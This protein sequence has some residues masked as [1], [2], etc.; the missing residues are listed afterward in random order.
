LDE[1]QP[2][3]ADP[4][5][6]TP[7]FSVVIPVYNRLDYTRE[8]LQAFLHPHA[9][10]IEVIVV[11]DGSTDETAEVVQSLARESC[12]AQIRLIRQSNSGPS[13]ARNHGLSE[14]RSDWVFFHDNDDIWLPW[15]ISALCELLTRTEIADTQIIFL[16]IQRF[17]QIAELGK[18][19]PA[20]LQLRRHATMLDMR[21]NDPL[22][23]VA[24][25]NVG[26]RRSVFLELGGYVPG[27]HHGEDT[28]LFF[29]AGEHGPVMIVAEPVMMGY[30]LSAPG[31]V[32]QTNSGD[33]IRKKRTKFLLDRNRA[34]LYP[35]PKRKRAL[36]L[37]RTVS[38][39]VSG[40]FGKGY[41]GPAY[42]VWWQGLGV[43]AQ[44][45][46][47]AILLKLPLTPLLHYLR[48]RNYAFRWRRA[49]G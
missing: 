4:V 20:P 22:S 23:L 27:I 7:T 39:T 38:F 36:V 49:V 26:F 47:W 48:P 3:D 40:Y 18:L 11:D 15:T 45:G 35:G 41:I 5:G 9:S 32:S 30:R 1:T 42:H 29:R 37:A 43:L 25:C 17:S 2:L 16:G 6:M 44:S 14:A 19:A 34:G 24:S 12:G 28:D 8:C 46:Q 13:R 33:E 10:G 31:S 21:L